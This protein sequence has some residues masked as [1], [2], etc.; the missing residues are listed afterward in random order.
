[1]AAEKDARKINNLLDLTRF[2][3][4]RT[5]PC[6]PK[7]SNATEYTLPELQHFHQRQ[8]ILVVLTVES[9]HNLN[10]TFPSQPI[11]ELQY[12]A[13][14]QQSIAMWFGA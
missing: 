11:Y 10:I 13:I 5:T 7:T 12:N 8:T 9:Y 14:L 4:T 3:R 1:M 6:A 2:L